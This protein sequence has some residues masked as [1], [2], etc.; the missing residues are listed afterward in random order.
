MRFMVEIWQCSRFFSE[1]L[2]CSPVNHYSAVAH[3]ACITASW[4][5]WPWPSN[6]L[7]HPW[8]LA[9]ASS[10]TWHT[11]QEV[12]RYMSHTYSITYYSACVSIL[13]CTNYDNNDVYYT[14][15]FTMLY[16]VLHRTVVYIHQIVPYYILVY[17]RW[18]CTVLYR[19]NLRYSIL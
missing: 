15:L 14:M 11:G 12:L 8:S 2:Q 9:G 1:F 5:I 17:V 4:V 6:T 7:A 3:Y 13:Y 10:L 18:L 16:A 19:T